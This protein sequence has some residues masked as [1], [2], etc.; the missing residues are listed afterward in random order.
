MSETAKQIWLFISIIIGLIIGG[1]IAYG[2][3]TYQILLAVTYGLGGNLIVAAL[4][5]IFIAIIVTI[6]LYKGVHPF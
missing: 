4:I 1:F 6:V 3:Y 2:I 5:F